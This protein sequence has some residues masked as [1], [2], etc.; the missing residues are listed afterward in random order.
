MATFALAHDSSNLSS[1]LEERFDGRDPDGRGHGLGDAAGS[2]ADHRGGFRRLH[3]QA[4]QPAHRRNAN[5]RRRDNAARLHHVREDAFRRRADYQRLACRLQ[6]PW[7]RGLAR[8]DG[9]RAGALVP[10]ERTVRSQGRR[11]V[12]DAPA[13][14]RRLVASTGLPILAPQ[15]LV[16]PPRRSRVDLS[17]DPP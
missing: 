14:R 7:H 11:G 6:N 17:R 3:R 12:R 16:G 1:G 5:F 2:Q 9:Q 4:D 10:A 8:C 13:W 15:S